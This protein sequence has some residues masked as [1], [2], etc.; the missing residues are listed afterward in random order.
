MNVLETVDANKFL[1]FLA[2][3]GGAIILTLISYFVYL[4]CTH[5]TFLPW[6]FLTCVV[7]TSQP[8]NIRY[9]YSAWL[10]D[11]EIWSFI[12]FGR[13]SDMIQQKLYELMDESLA[14][15]LMRTFFP[16]KLVVFYFK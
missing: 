15:N 13:F 8:Y 16:F 12:V 11:D 1:I 3:V 4:A 7:F 9:I 2:I 5:L 10:F 6:F 14:K